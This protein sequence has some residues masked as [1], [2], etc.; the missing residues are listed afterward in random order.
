MTAGSLRLNPGAEPHPPHKHPEEEF[1]LITEGTGE[2]K[3]D[4][5][6]TEGRSGH[7]DV[8]RGE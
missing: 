5:K 4:G 3:V 1:M 2:M 6:L 7:D 8:L